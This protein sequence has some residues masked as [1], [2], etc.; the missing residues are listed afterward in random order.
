MVDTKEE[1]L[2]SQQKKEQERRLRVTKEAEKGLEKPVIKA[3]TLGE[4]VKTFKPTIAVVGLGGAG[5]NITT[6]IAEKGFVG[7]MIIAANTD[8]IHLSTMSKADKLILFGEK[9]CKGHGCGGD[10]EL[11]AQAAKE[12]IGDFK[13]E[14]EGTNLV[15]LVAGM[16]GGAG[17]GAMPVVAELTREL[18]ALTIGCVTVPFT[19]E[20]TRREK[21]RE[22]IKALTESCDSIIVI[23][24]S[25]LREV[26]GNP[27]LKEALAVANA[28]IGAFVK[29]ITETITQTSLIN[30]DYSDIR[31]VME[32]GGLSTIG[33]GESVGKDKVA[34]AISQAI[35][36]PLL[37]ISN[38]SGYGVLIHIMGGEDLTLEEVEVTGELI[39]DK[40]PNTKRV[41]WSAKI[42]DQLTDRVR[43]MAVLTG[44]NSPFVEGK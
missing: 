28:L 37:D 38:I 24:N 16:G 3:N 31:A 25:K 14:L 1:T 36:V 12:N 21:A 42:D 41:I 39:L 19:I 8:I 5:C 11:G 33:I 43:V 26:V 32:R 22:A 35:A 10:P 20:K 13:A 40:V 27:P 6:W 2:V 7:G 9:L 30:L 34:K 23:D 29:N 17:T 18:G 44:V 4:L 15:F